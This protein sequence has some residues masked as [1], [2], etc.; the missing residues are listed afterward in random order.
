MIEI[1]KKSDVDITNI[2]L[3]IK[4]EIEKSK[5]D[6]NYRDENKMIIIDSLATLNDE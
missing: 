4:D 2:I 5:I 6:P 3:S 1:M